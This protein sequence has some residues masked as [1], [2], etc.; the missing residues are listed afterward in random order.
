[1]RKKNHVHKIS[2]TSSQHYNK[3]YLGEKIFKKLQR[4]TYKDQRYPHRYFVY[5]FKNEKEKDFFF[6]RE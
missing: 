5:Y 1:M 2:K 3:K 6:L 4:N